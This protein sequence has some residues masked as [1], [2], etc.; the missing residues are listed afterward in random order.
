M[1]EYNN[2]L[3]II[4]RV[5]RLEMLVDGH[6]STRGKLLGQWKRVGQPTEALIAIAPW[7]DKLMGIGT[8]NQLYQWNDHKTKLV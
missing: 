6:I 8:D 3:Y 4:D 1:T 2:N 5:D 7:N